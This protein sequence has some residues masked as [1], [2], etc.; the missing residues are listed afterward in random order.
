[1]ALKLSDPAKHHGCWL[2]LFLKS[3]KMLKKLW[4][5]FQKLFYVD[6]IMTGFL[7]TCPLR[8]CWAHVDIG[9]KQTQLRITGRRS[10][11]KG[12]QDLHIKNW[13]GYIT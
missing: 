4:K 1:M 5:P 13:M 8:K 9:Y 11:G 12:E 7:V 3:I 10:M 6:Q 2:Y